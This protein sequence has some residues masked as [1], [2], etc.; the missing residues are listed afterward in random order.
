MQNSNIQ[1]KTEDKAEKTA[2]VILTLVLIAIALVVIAVT[3]V[4]FM[5]NKAA[6]GKDPQSSVEDY[7]N[8]IDII[9]SDGSRLFIDE[10]PQTEEG[11]ELYSLLEGT[12]TYEIADISTKGRNSV[13][14]VNINCPDLSVLPQLIA[15]KMN[16]ELAGVVASAQKKSEVYNS[17]DTFRSEILDAVYKKALP[18]A[19]VSAPL[20]AVQAKMILERQFFNWTITNEAAKTNTLDQHAQDV[21]TASYGMVSYAPMVYIIPESATVA[22]VPDQNS[23]GETTDPNVVAQLLENKYAKN[24]IKGEALQWNTSIN[25]LPDSTISYYLDE[26]I[27]MIQWQEEECGMVGTFSEVFIADGSQLRRKIAGDSFGDMNFETCTDFA[28]DTNAVL[29]SGGDFYNH[30]RNCGICV[31]NKAIYRLD[32]ATSD[33]CY[34]TRDGDML[35]SYRNQFSTP[36]QVQQF[37]AENDILWSLGFGPVLIDE[38][39]DVTPSTYSWGEINDTYARAALGMYAKGHYLLMNLN[40]G[41][42]NLYNYATLRQAAD[43]MIERGCYKAYTLDGGQTATTVVNGELKNPVQFGRERTLSDIIYFASAVPNE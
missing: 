27:L 31:Y 9:T 42:G 5:R 25:F 22:P 3:A 33:D 18:Q 6:G 13:V 21:R 38:G 11:R 7:F 40:C 19:S 17:D 35:F 26:S 15:S 32:Y 16:E 4:F 2:S 29:A 39:K 1:T 43:A 12:W 34:I 41:Q 14:T 30:G 37:I 10:K 20:I 8:S 23:F 28:K 24:L 36:E